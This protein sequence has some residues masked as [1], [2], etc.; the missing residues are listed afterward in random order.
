MRENEFFERTTG[1]EVEEARTVAS[2][3]SRRDLDEPHVLAIEPQLRVHG[4]FP[5]TVGATGFGNSC[6]YPVLV[7]R[8]ES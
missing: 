1:A 5:E 6:E 2:D 8:C 4:P 7:C 3:G